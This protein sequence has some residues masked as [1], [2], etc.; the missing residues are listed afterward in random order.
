M[1]SVVLGGS[2]FI[3]LNLLDKLIKKGDRIRV[4]DHRLP[5]EKDRP[6]GVEFVQGNYADPTLLEQIEGADCVFHLAGPVD[7]KAINVDAARDAEKTVAH[8]IRLMEAC[9]RKAVRRLVFVSSGGAVYGV[10][11]SMP[12]PEGHPTEP[13]SAYGASKLAIE[14]YLHVYKHVWGLDYKVARCANV[15]GRHQSPFRQQGLIPV[16]LHKAMKGEEVEVWGTGDAVR[17]YVN[18]EDVASALA[19]LSVYSGKTDVF[20]VGSGSGV[21]VNELIGTVRRQTG[22]D[23]KARYLPGRS[24]DVPINILDCTLIERELGWGCRN[25]LSEGIRTTWEWMKCFSPESV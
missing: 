19:A 12:I 18:V 23:V 22:L 15:Y 21:S 1:K 7:L 4:I 3:G 25:S 16:I 2:G 13:I 24:F 17:D 8:S 6:A 10:P 11:K 5:S 9:V 20:N 14:K